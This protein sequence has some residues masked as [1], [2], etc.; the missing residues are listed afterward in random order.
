MK[1]PDRIL[2]CLENKPMLT[3]ELA[4]YLKVDSN[5]L[6]KQLRILEKEKLVVSN[7]VKGKKILFCKDHNKVLTADIYEVCKKKKHKFVSFNIK[8]LEWKL[9][10]QNEE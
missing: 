9:N 1:L 8:E 3:R 2:K 7:L 10:K 6:K 5:E 4:K